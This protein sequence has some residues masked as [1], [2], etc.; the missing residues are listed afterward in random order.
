MYVNLVCGHQFS[1][2]NKTNGRFSFPRVMKVIAFT[3][4]I[5]QLYKTG[6]NSARV[7]LLFDLAESSSQDIHTYHLGV[8]V[9]NCT[10][11]WKQAHISWMLKESRG[12]FL[13][14]LHA[15]TIIFLTQLFKLLLRSLLLLLQLPSLLL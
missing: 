2:L 7:D 13:S 14:L 11:K 15:N 1:Q 12:P 4:Y 5:L 3:R 9:V 8:S 6:L 10:A